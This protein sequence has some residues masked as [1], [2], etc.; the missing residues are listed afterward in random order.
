MTMPT[1]SIAIR[2][3]DRS[4]R[5]N[6]LGETI[7]ALSRAGVFSTDVVKRISLCDSGSPDAQAFIERHVTALQLSLPVLRVYLTK[8]RLTANEN[9]ARALKYASDADADWVLFLEDDIDVI[10][11]FAESV[12]RW[13]SKYASENARIYTFG[14]T[15]PKVTERWLKNKRGAV[16]I[17]SREFF[18]TTAY[19]IRTADAKQLADWQDRHP[20][21]NG[22]PQSHDLLIP[23]WLAERY[24]RSQRWVRASV[25]SF[26]Q[27]I[28]DV[29]GLSP[30]RTKIYRY[31]TWPGEFWI[32]TLIPASEQKEQKP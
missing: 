32:Y 17:S 20:T 28:G 30:G 6:Y 21:Y 13:L 19:A 24:P 1:L 22:K 23:A 14:S 27:H 16:D 3:V 5:P 10:G 8:F 2:T 18:G 11:R 29:S 25:P 26:V 12:S 7:A 15:H 31:V 4:P 9:A